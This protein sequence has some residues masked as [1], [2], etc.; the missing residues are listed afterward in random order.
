M[1]GRAHPQAR[2]AEEASAMSDYRQRT[3]WE[4][5]VFRRLLEVAFPGRDFMFY[6][7]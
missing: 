3:G 5:R 1:E 4:E 6:M 2:Y 7:A